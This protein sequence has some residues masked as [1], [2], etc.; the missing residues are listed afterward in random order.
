MKKLIPIIL[1]IIFVG[2]NNKDDILET[3]INF[4]K[5]IERISSN[6]FEAGLIEKAERYYPPRED[7]VSVSQIWFQIPI[8]AYWFYESFDGVFIPYSI[9]IDAINYYSGMIDTLKIGNNTTKFLSAELKYK[10]TV[11][12]ENEYISPSLNSLGKAVVP[13]VFKS[14]YVVKLTLEW[15]QTCGSLCGLW[16]EKERIV[17]FDSE[18]N[19]LKVFLDG[20]KRIMIS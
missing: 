15:E 20:P 9:T 3:P 5:S 16:I 18:G 11:S 6:T 10:A 8:T 7:V 14:V 2:C 4:T 17:V 1:V 12:F 13:E 19:I